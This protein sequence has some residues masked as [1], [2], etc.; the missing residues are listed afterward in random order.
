MFTMVATYRDAGVAYMGMPSWASG[1]RET[2]RAA[3]IPT[4]CSLSQARGFLT[5]GAWLGDE[6]PQS[7]GILLVCCAVNT[8]DKS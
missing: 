7:R 8:L 3:P 2:T 6:G 5:V 1:R 4:S